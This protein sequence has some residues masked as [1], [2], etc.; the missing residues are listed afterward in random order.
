MDSI[1]ADPPDALVVTLTGP[2]DAATAP[3]CA[4]LIADALHRIPA[5]LTLVLDLDRLDFIASG[6][7]R[8]LF[9]AADAA[10]GAGVPLVI[11]VGRDHYVRTTIDRIDTA[12]RLPLAER[13]D[14][15][16]AGTR[17]VVGS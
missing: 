6:G 8:V 11:V 17:R 12:G 2:L 4:A 16:T 3:E 5:G 10:R 15:R 13:F 9:H 7:V 1:T 14:R